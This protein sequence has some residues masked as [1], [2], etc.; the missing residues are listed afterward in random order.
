[1]ASTREPG[2]SERFCICSKVGAARINQSIYWHLGS[3]GLI[4]TIE[5]VL[6]PSHK[7]SN[8]HPRAPD[9]SVPTLEFRRHIKAAKNRLKNRQPH[10][11]TF[12]KIS[13]SDLLFYPELVMVRN[14]LMANHFRRES[15]L[16]PMGLRKESVAQE[17]ALSL[18]LR[19]PSEGFLI[20]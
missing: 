20:L 9:Q 1:M 14:N 10:S 13:S 6:T 15:A 2:F 7:L 16:G 17:G 4:I 19:R 18:G 11:A 3:K 5:F 12:F 8:L